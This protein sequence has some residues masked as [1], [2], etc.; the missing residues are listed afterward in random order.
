MDVRGVTIHNTADL[1]G[2]SDDAEQYTRATHNQNMGYARVHYYVDECGAWKNLLDTEVG[3]HAG[4]GTGNGNFSTVAIEIIMNGSGS[5]EDEGAE[6]NGAMLAAWLLH[7]FG[8][9]VNQLYT[10][11]HWMGLPDSVVRGARK[12]CP[13]YILPHWGEFVT[14]VAAYLDVLRNPVSPV[15]NIPQIKEEDKPLTQ[16]ERAQLDALANRVANLE[17]GANGL[18]ADIFNTNG[19]VTALEAEIA[20]LDSKK[21]DKAVIYQTIHDIPEGEFRET[22]QGLINRG[23]IKDAAAVNMTYGEVRQLVI[24]LRD[25][26]VYHKIADV[27]EGEFRDTVRSLA[28]KGVL[29]GSGKENGEIIID[30]PYESVRLIVLLARQGVFG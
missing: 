23:V 15:Q 20:S 21:A 6:R 8:L 9:T 19:R 10:H 13:V 5:A 29:K 26:C 14:R 28:D 24:A 17:G 16:E 2:V 12:N 25:K 4:D 30:L 11:N 18:N 7:R 27:P 1:E 3:W 22:V